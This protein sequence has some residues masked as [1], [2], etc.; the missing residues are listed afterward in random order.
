[1]A[2]ESLIQLLRY[3]RGLRTDPI[4]ELRQSLRCG[5]R[6]PSSAL[7]LDF[8]ASESLPY[9]GRMD[10]QTQFLER[11][12]RTWSGTRSKGVQKCGDRQIRAAKGSLKR[13]W[14]QPD[15]RSSS[16]VSQ[17]HCDYVICVAGGGW[18][19]SL[20]EYKLT[21]FFCPGEPLHVSSFEF[22]FVAVCQP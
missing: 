6:R 22:V 11:E 10:N 2:V 15:L 14:G 12:T 1:M 19:M 20:S 18:F 8:S 3:S 5:T 17:R 21:A 16:Q 13:Q 7:K 4:V 9:Q